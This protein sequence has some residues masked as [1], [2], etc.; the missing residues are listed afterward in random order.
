MII[1]IFT[2]T[3]EEKICLIVTFVIVFSIAL[4][5]ELRERKKMSNKY[6]PQNVS[7]EDLR[8]GDELL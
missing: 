7:A 3:T 5:L 6:V 2:M 1:D 8:K 4:A